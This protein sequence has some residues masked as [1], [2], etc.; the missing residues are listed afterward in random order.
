VRI[1]AEALCWECVCLKLYGS[2]TISALKEI[3]IIPPQSTWPTKNMKSN[4]Y[5]FNQIIYL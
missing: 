1:E 4:A 3:P 5:Y 2:I